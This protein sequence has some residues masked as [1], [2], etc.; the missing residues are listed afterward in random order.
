[1]NSLRDILHFMFKCIKIKYKII[2]KLL[3]FQQ[4][5]LNTSTCGIIIEVIFCKK[6][7]IILFKKMTMIFKN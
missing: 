6:N 3:I 4:F 5:Y 1:M 2:H 7:H